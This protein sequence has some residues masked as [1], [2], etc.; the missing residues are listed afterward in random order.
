MKRQKAKA[1]ELHA[2]E[3]KRLKAS[4][5]RMEQ[6]L[7]A[8]RAQLQRVMVKRDAHAADLNDM[9]QRMQRIQ[10]RAAQVQEDAQRKA[11]A[12]ADAFVKQQLLKQ[13][14]CCEEVT[15]DLEEM[16]QIARFHEDSARQLQ[17]KLT[18]CEAG[19]C[20]HVKRLKYALEQAQ[21]ENTTLF[22]QIAVY[23]N[24]LQEQEEELL[25]QVDRRKSVTSDPGTHSS[26]VH[27]TSP[28]QQHQKVPP[29]DRGHD[30]AA[31]RMSQPLR[32]LQPKK[33]RSSNS[34]RPKQTKAPKT[35]AFATLGEEA[36]AE[37]FGLM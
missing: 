23:E 31:S 35:K 6:T 22:E 25:A 18:A 8:E 7:V 15:Q 37:R 2:I 5:E 13:E 3:R 24:V 17:E 26:S 28:K 36:R 1:R 12:E 16:E 14:Q 4:L 10:H 27:T 19:E 34:Q 11:K 32:E 9:K 20:K 33:P 21:S 29:C 30:T